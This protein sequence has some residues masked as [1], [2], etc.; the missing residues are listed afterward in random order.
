MSY[1]ILVL[2]IFGFHLQSVLFGKWHAVSLNYIYKCPLINNHY[3]YLNPKRT[4]QRICH[5]I[6]GRHNRYDSEQS[7][8]YQENGTHFEIHYG[9]GSMSGFYLRIRYVLQRFVLMVSYLL[10]L[11]TNPDWHF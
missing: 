6:L 2:A 3:P 7:S 4:V 8:T 1:L 9:S 10:K 5:N 11:H